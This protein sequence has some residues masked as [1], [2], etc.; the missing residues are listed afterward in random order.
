MNNK[1]IEEI[2]SKYKFRIDLYESIL[3]SME[4]RKPFFFQ[5]RKLKEFN[6]KCNNFQELQ[7]ENKDLNQKLLTIKNENEKLK[8]KY[9]EMDAK[10]LTELNNAKN[11][12]FLLKK[13][14]EDLIKQNN[15]LL[16]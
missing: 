12:I 9:Q 15:F 4:D 3:K 7:I 13:N 2:I 6:N 10:N 11:D 1:I 8:Q 16:S 5:K 14:Y